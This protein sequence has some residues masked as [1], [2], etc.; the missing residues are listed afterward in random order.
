M[1]DAPS[2]EIIDLIN[3]K[4]LVLLNDG[5]P[6]RQDI[7]ADGLSALDLTF[8]SP[9]L[10]SKREWKTHDH[11]LGSDH[12]PVILEV[13]TRYKL[14]EFKPQPPW[15]L[16]QADWSLFRQMLYSINFCI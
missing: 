15:K 8:A 11:L 3:T 7:N 6:T 5:S 9:N 16:D 10:G 2:P 13:K 4:G 12:Y 14:S 1:D